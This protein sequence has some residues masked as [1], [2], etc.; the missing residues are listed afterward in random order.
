MSF[1]KDSYKKAFHGRFLPLM[2]TSDDQNTRRVFS[3]LR[4]F[5]S[6]APTDDRFPKDS[7]LS[8]GTLE[9]W[10]KTLGRNKN[11]DAAPL[12]KLVKAMTIVMPALLRLLQPL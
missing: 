10:H 9:Q 6:R 2:L 12:P 7:I 4:S 11:H 5:G 1:E 8:I 3:F